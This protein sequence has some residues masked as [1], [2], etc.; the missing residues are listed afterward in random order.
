MLIDTRKKA[1]LK[2]KEKI[3]IYTFITLNITGQA[4]KAQYWDDSGRK[5]FR[6]KTRLWEVL[7]SLCA[8]TVRYDKTTAHLQLT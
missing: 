4:R 8:R 5:N 2:T 7:Q 3:C 1:V 6:C